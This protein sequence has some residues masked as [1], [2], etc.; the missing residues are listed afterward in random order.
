MPDILRKNG[1][2]FSASAASLFYELNPEISDFGDLPS[3]AQIT[4]PGIQTTAE[5][6]AAL[7]KGFLVYISRD[8][9]LKDEVVLTVE[10]VVAEQPQFNGLAASVFGG[11][12]SKER[13]SN[14]IGES[15]GHLRDVQVFIRED[16]QPFSTESLRQFGDDAGAL[17][18]VMRKV[19][20]SGTLSPEDEEVILLVSKDLATK[21]R[22]LNASKSPDDVARD[23]QATMVVNVKPATDSRVESSRIC[24]SVEALF[25]MRKQC[26]A[27]L[28]P[29][30]SLTLPVADYLVW[31]AA[32]ES[33]TPLTQP[34]RRVL[35]E[36]E[37]ESV[38]VE[39]LLG[40]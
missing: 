5:I 2:Q 23:P 30:A 35:L 36:K 13:L 12:H 18:L 34:P 10:K 24:Y 16:V 3:G 14:A 21:S 40:K 37:G 26:S 4:V 38:P 17:L 11:R 27:T 32:N 22:G 39:L 20:S 9:A 31:M 6:Q 7:A 33:S 28:G 1:I 19:F 29:H 15:V 8:K 25:A